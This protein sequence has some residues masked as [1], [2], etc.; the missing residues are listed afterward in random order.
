MVK[1]YLGLFVLLTVGI[2]TGMLLSQWQQSP[3][4]SGQLEPTASQSSPAGGS[5]TINVSRSAQLTNR[6]SAVNAASDPL[7]ELQAQVTAMS[8]NIDAMSENI[9]AMSENINAMSARLAVLET[10]DDTTA[11]QNTNNRQSVITGNP[12]T[13][14]FGGLIAAGIDA[15]TAGEIAR[16]QSAAALARLDLRDRAIREGYMGTEQYRD[17]MRALSAS[18]KNVRETVGVDAWDKYLYHT[19]QNNRVA[20]GSVMLGSAAEQSGLAAGDVLLRYEDEP[21]YQYSDLRSATIA[22][23]R[24]EI[25]SL[26]VLRAGNTITLSVPRGPLGIRIE[27]Q[28]VDPDNS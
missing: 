12:Q 11:S 16:E 18:E 6:T 26:T 4:A 2:V 3:T 20:V 24:D 13:D 1:R 23:E 10:S 15:Q 7:F 17:E 5:Q 19:G 9:S 8:E 25:V 27:S 28:R 21:L 22:G 14:L